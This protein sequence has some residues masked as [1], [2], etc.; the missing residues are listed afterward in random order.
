M[1]TTPMKIRITLAALFLCLLSAAAHADPLVISG[2]QFVGEG[3]QSTSINIS[4]QNFN[5]TFTFSAVNFAGSTLLGASTRPGGSAYL[6]SGTQR[7]NGVGTLCYNGGCVSADGLGGGTISGEFTF[8]AES[9]FFPQLDPNGPT[10]YTISVPLILTGTVSG[11]GD[12][13][14]ETKLLVVGQGQLTYTY[15]LVF[16]GGQPRYGF[17]RVEATFINNTPEPAT[18]LL[19]MTGLAGAAGARR[20]RKVLSNAGARGGHPNG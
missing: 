13:F 6:L 3:D 5:S 2:G 14:P 16:V 15:D 18:L 17:R 7:F 1:E 19:L 8:V 4:G 20:R 11:S 12:N 9:Y 10:T